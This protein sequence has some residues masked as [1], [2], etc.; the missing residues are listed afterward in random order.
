MKASNSIAIEEQHKDSIDV[1][2]KCF[3]LRWLEKLTTETGSCNSTF[4]F[5]IGLIILT[6]ILL[7]LFLCLGVP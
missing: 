7:V 5:R 2:N 1:E 4:F 6:P 3:L